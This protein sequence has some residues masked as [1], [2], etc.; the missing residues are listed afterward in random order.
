MQGNWL[1]IGELLAHREFAAAMPTPDMTPSTAS[2]W[3]ILLRAL[4]RDITALGQ[5]A[6]RVLIRPA[7]ETAS[8]IGFVLPSHGLLWG[9]A[10]IFVVLSLVVTVVFMAA[11]LFVLRDM[12]LNGG[13][14]EGNE[15]SI[16]LEAADGQPL[17]RVGPLKVSH[18]ARAEFPPTLVA[19]VLSIEDRRFYQ[20]WG[21]DPIGIGRAATRNYG[22][23]RIV[24]GGSTITQQLVKL[25]LVGNQ[26]TFGRKLRE[27]LTAVWLEMRLEKDEILTRYLNSVY[28]GAG[29]Q[30]IPAALSAI[31]T[32]GPR[33]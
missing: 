4:R 2:A 15:Q 33:N 13:I 31:L 10:K 16:V 27:A 11:M 25:R 8:T 29:A 1:G 26:R 23:G 21:I 14:P 3:G 28:M 20:H 6:R 24:E 18:A 7:R 9:T 17:G 12:P 19:A 32:N 5:R 22:S 30:G